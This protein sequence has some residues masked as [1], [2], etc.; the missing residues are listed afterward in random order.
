[1]P[2]D[3]ATGTTM[4]VAM[5]SLG[6]SIG[7]AVF[8]TVQLNQL[9][10]NIA[11]LYTKYAEYKD[12]IDMSIKNQAAIYYDTVPSDLR[13]ALIHAN[14]NALRSVFYTMIPFAGLMFVLS[15]CL[16]HIPLRTTMVK[17]HGN[18]QDEGKKPDVVIKE[19]SK[20]TV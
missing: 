9:S 1:M 15:L 10:S 5:R 6:G 4:Y 16:K 8:Q 18:T 14:V 13:A 12:L 20:E 17:T 11:P 3:I 7:L 2:R 19:Q